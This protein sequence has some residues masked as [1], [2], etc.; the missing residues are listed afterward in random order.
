MDDKERNVNI[1][2]V[3]CTAFFLVISV[4]FFLW[5]GFYQIKMNTPEAYFLCV[6]RTVS[7][8]CVPLFLMISGYLLSKRD[9]L[10]I[11]KKY[12]S[13][14]AE[15]LVIYL[16]CT[17]I[18][19]FFRKEILHEN[20]SFIDMI[21]NVISFSQ[22][23]WYVFMYAGLYLLIPFLNLIWK[24]LDKTRDKTVLLIILCS[25]SA[26]TSVI[27][28]KE[29][30]LPAIWTG[31]YPITYYYLGAFIA[32]E[33][34]YIKIRRSILFLI[35]LFFAFA[36][37]YF[38]YGISGEG[39][40]AMGIW[41]DWGSLENIILPVLLFLTIIRQDTVH[42][43][44]GIKKVL[45]MMSGLIYVAFM[46]SYISDIVAWKLFKDVI[47]V[48]GILLKYIPSV[49]VSFGLAMIMS[50]VFNIAYGKLKGLLFGVKR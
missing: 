4:H 12:I 37:G 28:I 24:N 44:P 2:I 43:K 38:N 13:K 23:S 36:I 31:I 9:Y 50:W 20:M 8:S 40:F 42:M 26:A 30:L 6:I 5:N 46:L 41:N 10:P 39:I 29:A 11:S 45:Q 49:F 21:K 17:V 15:L 48:S 25:L 18:L 47:P 33:H 32:D 35:W 27:N 34:R 16:M 22:Y 1:D 19:I 7:M 14:L 3:R